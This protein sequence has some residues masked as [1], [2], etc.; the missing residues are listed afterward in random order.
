M[1]RPFLARSLAVIGLVGATS[2][3]IVY[4]SG[5]AQADGLVDTLMMGGAAIVNGV[6]AAA[7]EAL[8]AGG[9]AR[10]CDEV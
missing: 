7:P 4:N 8:L 5:P 6:E 3:G 9:G 10:A 1:L 2:L